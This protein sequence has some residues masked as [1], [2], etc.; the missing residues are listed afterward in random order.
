MTKVEYIKRWLKAYALVFAII[1]PIQLI[2][3]SFWGFLK[4]KGIF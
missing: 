2:A 3:L 1:L 4:W